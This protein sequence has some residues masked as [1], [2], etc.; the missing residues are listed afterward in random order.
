VPDTQLSPHFSLF[1]FRCPCCNRVLLTEATR[2]AQR[3][4]PVR[5]DFGVIHIDS[6][7]RCPRE[8]AR[9]GGKPDSQHLTGLAADIAIYNDSERFALIKA[10][11]DHGF[12][13]IGIAKTYVHADIGTITGPMI[14]TYYA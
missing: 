8:N 10:L 3:L 9:V 1:E 5:G 11:L 13:R 14:W 12:L 2:L 4:E 7:F 6:G